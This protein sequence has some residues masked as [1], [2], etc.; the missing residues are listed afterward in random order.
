M[1]KFR[2]LLWI[3]WVNESQVKILVFERSTWVIQ[4]NFDILEVRNKNLKEIRFI[5]QLKRRTEGVTA[6][7][8]LGLIINLIRLPVCIIQQF[9]IWMSPIFSISST[10]TS[11]VISGAPLEPVALNVLTKH[12]LLIL[13]SLLYFCTLNSMLIAFKA[14]HTITCILTDLTALGIGFIETIHHISH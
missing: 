11:I 8:L 10:L 1:T 6:Y 5:D 13:W 3:C 9:N 12:E 4:S 14:W 7:C 2:A